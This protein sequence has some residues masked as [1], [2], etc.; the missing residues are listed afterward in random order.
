MTRP[1]AQQS[2]EKLD[3]KRVLP[4]FVIVLIDILGLTIIIPLL[5][6]YATAFGAN[7]VMIGALGTAYPLFQLIGSPLLGSLS[8]RLGRKPVLIISQMG[9]LAGFLILGFANSLMLLFIARIVDGFTGGN[10]VVAQAAITDSTTEKTR[11]QGL[12]LIGAAFGLG[13]TL[14]PA[15]AGVSLV[16]SNNNYAVPAFIAAGFSL[17]SILLTAFWFKETLSEER[18]G[19]SRK[20]GTGGIIDR[21]FGA[22]RNPL[23]GG[24]LLL[25]FMQQIIFG[26]VEQLLSLFT[27]SQLGMNAAGN[28]LLFL[29]VGIVLVIVQGKYIGPLSRRF[30]ER[31]L[32]YAGTL[33]LGVGTL[34]MALSPQVPVP[35]YSRSEILNELEHG[36]AEMVNV[37]LPPETSPG[38]LGIAWIAVSLVPLTVGAGLLSPSINSLITRRTDG[39]DTGNVLGVSSA[40]VSAANTITPLVGGTLFQFLGPPAPFLIGGVTMLVLTYWAVRH[41]RPGPEGW[42]GENAQ[43]SL[44]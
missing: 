41:I 40:L 14:G 10:I 4:V 30:G 33:L 9:T 34:L 29:L 38:W 36:T 24:L 37:P 16:L 26:G 5:P 13:F 21:S 8:D 28:T 12:G 6:L 2:D 1:D 3:F 22:L 43:P 19:E 44:A 27:L 17:L 23:I 20:N 39:Q 31:K 35:W 11:T 7:A 15:I 42:G 32:I 18:R 25:I